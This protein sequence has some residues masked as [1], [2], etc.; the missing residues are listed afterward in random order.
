[1]KN[2]RASVPTIEHIEALYNEGNEAELRRL[3]EV[4]AKRSNQRLSQLEKYG[5]EGTAAYKRAQSF[6]E[7]SDYSKNERYSR[8]K[9]MDIDSLY[10]QV[11]N[12]SNFLRWQT[13]TVKGEMERREKIFES[14]YSQRIDP[15]TGE[16]VNPPLD[17]PTNMDIDV[18]KKK[19]LDFLDTDAW[20]ELKKHIYHKNILNEAGEAVAA[21]ASVE[22][23]QRAMTDYVNKETDDDLITIWDNWTKI[24]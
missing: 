3:N 19:F 1:M 5:F 6:I 20:E 7:D 11:V 15:E 23:L 18:F 22:D 10:E 14:L 17:L 4:L 9:K 16:I 2:K 12:E 24:T 21:G 8:S 13:S